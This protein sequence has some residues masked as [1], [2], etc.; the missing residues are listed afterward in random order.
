MA[1]LHNGIARGYRFD[2]H[3]RFVLHTCWLKAIGLGAEKT[4]PE[5]KIGAASGA[6]FP[7]FTLYDV[8]YKDQKLGVDSQVKMFL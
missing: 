4:V 2:K 1:L 7:H 3:N 8:S 5:L 6:V